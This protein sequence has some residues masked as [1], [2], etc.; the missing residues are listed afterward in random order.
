MS[1]RRLW[2]PLDLIFVFKVQCVGLTFSIKG[3]I[4]LKLN[5]DLRA[6]SKHLLFC[7]IC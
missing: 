4:K 5:N 7:I 3:G 2:L 1:H 6:K